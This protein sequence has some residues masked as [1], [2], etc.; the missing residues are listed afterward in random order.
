MNQQ[1]QVALNTIFGIESE[2]VPAA[3]PTAIVP[4]AVLPPERT[5]APSSEESTI[6]EIRAEEDFEFSRGA[7][8]TVA[9]EGQSILHRA[10][11]AAEQTDRASNFEAVAQIMRATVETHRAIQDIHKQAHELRAAIHASRQPSTPVGQVNIEQGIVF[12]GGA[13]ELLRLIDPTR[14]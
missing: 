3:A 9:T 5:T 2:T 6:H 14:K 8:K 1:T 10:I 12:Q 4:T 11:E 7:L 13:D